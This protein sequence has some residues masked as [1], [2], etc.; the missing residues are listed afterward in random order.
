MRVRRHQPDRRKLP[1]IEQRRHQQ[2][3]GHRVLV[4]RLGQRQC[5]RGRGI[6]T[7]RLQLLRQIAARRIDAERQCA[8][9]DPHDRDRHTEQK[10][11]EQ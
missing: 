3:L 10:L 6:F 2:L 4:A 8:Q 5:Q 7:L 1:G 11:F 9:Q